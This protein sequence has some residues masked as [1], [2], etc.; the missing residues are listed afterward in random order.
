MTKT[1]SGARVMRQ[2]QYLQYCKEKE[3]PVF[4][5]TLRKA[6]NEALPMKWKR[7]LCV[8]YYL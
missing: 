2:M 7:G 4:P 8:E 3:E 6:H 5:A 1:F